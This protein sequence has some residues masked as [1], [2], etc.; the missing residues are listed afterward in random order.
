[1]K[2]GTL[3]HSIPLGAAFLAASL[4]TTLAQDTWSGASGGEWNTL[5]NW[6]LNAVPGAGV[7]AIIPSGITANYNLPMSAASFGILTNNGV[8]NINAAGFNNAGIF[9]LTAA[10]GTFAVNNG[11]VVNVTG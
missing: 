3:S 2:T 9:M 7:M 1:M 8:L 10:G 6:S 5:G 4:L 11:G